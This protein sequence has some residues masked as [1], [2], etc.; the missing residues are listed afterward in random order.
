VRVNN[1]VN[2][3][4]IDWAIWFERVKLFQNKIIVDVVRI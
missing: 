1:H 3:S 2:T 4:N